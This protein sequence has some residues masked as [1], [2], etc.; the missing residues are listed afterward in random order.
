MP[1]LPQLSDGTI[2]VRP[3]RAEDCDAMYTAVVESMAELSRWLPWCH[4][5]YARE[6]AASF[7]ALSAQAWTQAAHY[8]FAILAAGNDSFLGGIGIN[9]IVRPN[10]L[11]N[12][13]YWV[14]TSRTGQGIAS[15]AVRLVSRYAFESL[16][17]TRLEIAC[18]PT[19]A[20]SR[21]VAEK[22]GARFEALA[23]NRLVMHGTACDASVYG[24]VPED[25]PG[26]R[27][28]T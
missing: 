6:D 26:V 23:R 14:R 10:R 7:I 17:F 22:A 4:A 18:I 25:L 8:P 20:L 5:G 3:H 15:A 16:G 9:H 12:M 28:S 2:V 24:L 11:G 21:R 13:G 1:A 19:N 27:A